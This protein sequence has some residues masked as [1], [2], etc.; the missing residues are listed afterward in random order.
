MA[1]IL[2]VMNVAFF[3]LE[4][5]V[6]L[7]QAAVFGLLTLMFM[8]AASTGHDSAAHADETVEHELAEH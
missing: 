7:I 3:G 2:P 5:F 8:S 1:F 4:F 6:G